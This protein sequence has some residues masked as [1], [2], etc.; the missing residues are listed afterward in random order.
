[1]EVE[2][3]GEERAGWT[4]SRNE[5]S[6]TVIGP[7]VQAS[8]IHGGVHVHES[9]PPPPPIPRQLLGPVP[10][11]TNRRAELSQ[12]DEVLNEDRSNLV[13][14]SGPGGVGKTAL[15]MRWAHLVRDRF[16][17][18]QLYVDLGGFGGGEPVDPGEALGAFLRALGLAAQRIPAA[19]AEQAA[20]YRSVTADRALLLILDNAYSVGQVRTLLPA[21]TASLAVVTSRSRLVGLVPDGARLI[22]IEPLPTHDSVV[23]LTRAVGT[24]RIADERVQ[25]EELAELCGGLPIALCVVAARLAARPRLSVRRIALELA[26]EANRLGGLSA[27]DGRSVQFACD[28]S[29]RSLDPSAAA[30]Y[31]R[32]ALHPGQ[33]FGTGPIVALMPGIR[34]GTSATGQPD[35][36]EVLLEMSLLQEIDEERFRYHDL[37]R[38]HARQKSEVD[39]L[40]PDRDAARLAMSEWYLAAAR[41]ADSVLTPYRRRLPYG[42]STTPGEL[43]IL[44]TREQALGWLERER[45][46][47]IAAARLAMDCGHPDLAWQ[48]S[49]VVWPLLLYGKHYRDRMDIDLRGVQA[50]QAW[51]HAWAEAVMRKRLGRICTKVGDYEA[52]ERHTRAAIRRYHDAGDVR[53]GL[54]AQEGLAA[55]YRDSGRETEAATMFTRVLAANRECGDE[56]S[57]GLNLINLGMLLPTLGRPGEALDLLR[58]A[59]GLFAGLADIDPY[60]EVRVRIGLARAYLAV[61][62]LADAQQFAQ[63]AAYRMRELG[64]EHETAEALDVLGQV[65]QRR[66]DRTAARHHYRRAFE[67][68]DAL[69]SSRASALRDQLAEVAEVADVVGSADPRGTAGPPA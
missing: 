12:L 27:S 23:L 44:V 20:L 45:L 26:D 6:G 28:V 57:I 39:E 18:G 9:A 11:F 3:I 56:R 34:A 17:D 36:L 42:F 15:A 58:E 32:L 62:Q 67:I 33:E 1:M 14:L 53:G 51:D 55:L 38:L 61:G 40:P 69:G 5:L 25:A 60:N 2:R 66:G 52:A 63:E 41:Q 35:P 54:D 19:L 21:S 68:L 16:A 10:H 13:V 31:R 37:L 48:L 8:T 64:S 24:T 22:E 4:A 65:A 46:N 7:S 43:P 29:Y 49:D 50:A 59:A 30:L 47:L